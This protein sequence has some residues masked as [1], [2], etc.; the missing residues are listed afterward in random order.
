MMDA[1]KFRD[2]LI[3]SEGRRRYPYED[4]VGK[5]SIGVGR[6]LD[7]VGLSDDEI[8]VLLNNDMQRA[9][10]DAGTL[11]YFNDLDEVRQMVICDLVFN[12][13]LARFRD[14][15]IRANAALLDGDY[16]RAADELVDSKWY[17]QVGVRGRRNVQMMRTGEYA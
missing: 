2:H 14:G 7:D 13:G 4:T 1:L 15:F 8:D 3:L 6:N 17:R 12:M 11:P 5:T 9:L 10:A 16:D